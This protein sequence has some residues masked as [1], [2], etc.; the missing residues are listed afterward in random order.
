MKRAI[1]SV[2]FLSILAFLSGG[3]TTFL[4]SDDSS[5]ENYRALQHFTKVYDIIKRQYVEE[6]KDDKLIEG[7]IRGMLDSLDPHS[8][9]YTREEFAESQADIRGQFGGLG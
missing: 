6:P 4:L 3:V 5:R 8:V 2:I 9:Y 7:A 1:F